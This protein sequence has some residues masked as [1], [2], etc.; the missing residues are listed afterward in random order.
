MAAD[1][2]KFPC[3]IERVCETFKISSLYPEQETSLK[4]LVEGKNVYASLPTGYG[5]L[6]IFFAATVLFHVIL[7]RPCGSSKIL[8]IS[9][10]KTLMED[11]VAY[12]RSLG[13]SAIALHDEQLEECLKQV[14][15]GAFTYLFASPE[16]MLCGKMAKAALQ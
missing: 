9:P 13:L 11:Q 3:A 12:L 15:K 6:L 2:R 4:A 8:V 1:S 10:L 5:K 14:E 16:K 7:K